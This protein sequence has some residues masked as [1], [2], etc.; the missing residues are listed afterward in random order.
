M[1]PV[2][3][4][5]ARNVSL[6]FL[7]RADSSAGFLA[8]AGSSLVANMDDLGGT[9]F[10]VSEIWFLFSIRPGS[11][12]SAWGEGGEIEKQSLTVCQML[13]LRGRSVD[14]NE[15][16]EK[17]GGGE[18]GGRKRRKK[19]EDEKLKGKRRVSSSTDSQ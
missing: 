18:R 15:E 2:V 10:S 11:D 5:R 8:R 9:N 16:E 7:A 4:A 3:G 19:E 1:V 17:R 13:A 6:G 14:L 12:A